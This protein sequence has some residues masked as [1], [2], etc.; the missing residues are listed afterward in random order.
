MKLA[1]SIKVLILHEVGA[2]Y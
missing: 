1:S 2:P